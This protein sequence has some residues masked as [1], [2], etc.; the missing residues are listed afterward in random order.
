MVVSDIDQNRI[1]G[2]LA[3]PC[4]MSYTW[5][6]EGSRHRATYSHDIPT[7]TLQSVSQFIERCDASTPV[8]Q[9]YRISLQDVVGWGTPDTSALR[10]RLYEFSSLKLD[11]V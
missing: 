5:S 10:L 7:Q 8:A 1:T 11:F 6:C 2:Q 4:V 3:W 9:A